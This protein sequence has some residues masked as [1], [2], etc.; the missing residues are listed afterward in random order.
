MSI[1]NSSFINSLYKQICNVFLISF[2]ITVPNSN[3]VSTIHENKTFEEIR[4]EYYNYLINFAVRAMK[5]KKR[6]L[7]NTKSDRVPV[8][9][10]LNKSDNLHYFKL[11]LF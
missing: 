2:T 5:Q 4:T 3:N 1:I 10:A 11:K 7:S 8:G 6:K 9:R